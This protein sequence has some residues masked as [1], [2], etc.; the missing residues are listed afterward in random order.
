MANSDKAIEVGSPELKVKMKLCDTRNL[1]LR[2]V[3]DFIDRKGYAPTIGEIQRSCQISS[4]SVVA[5]HL[6]VLENEGYIR[7]DSEVTRGIKIPGKEARVISIPLL[8]TIAAGEPMPV[9][10]EETWRSMAVEMIDMPVHLLPRS[11]EVYALKVKGISMV[12]ALVDDGDIVVMEKASIA[13]DGEMVAVWLK[14][15]RETTLK[16]LYIEPGKV[17]LQPANSAIGPIYCRPDEVEI[18]GRVIGV[19][20]RL[21]DFDASEVIPCSK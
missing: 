4:K 1:I 18:Q 11:T 20:R 10:T 15:R 6:R 19:I 5:Y 14:E 21:A 12:D 3:T 17:R 9:L 8:G 7:R 2:F 16:R 13:E